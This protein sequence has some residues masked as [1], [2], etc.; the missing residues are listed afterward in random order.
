MGNYN[1]Q[2]INKEIKFKKNK[3]IK[4]KILKINN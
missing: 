1:L 4:N 3:K 2:M